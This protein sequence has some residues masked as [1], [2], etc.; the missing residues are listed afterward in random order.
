[1]MCLSVVGN[2]TRNYTFGIGALRVISFEVQDQ[3]VYAGSVTGMFKHIHVTVWWCVDGKYS[4][5]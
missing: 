1:M 3:K 2:L 5:S 4:R